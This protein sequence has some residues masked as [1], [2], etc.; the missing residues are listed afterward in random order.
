MTTPA[1]GIAVN[2]F[3][4]KGSAAEVGEMLRLGPAVEAAGF[5]SLWVGDHLLWHTP[6]MDALTLLGGYAATTEHVTL[7]T[8]IYLLG[9]RQPMHAA[10]AI[11]ALNLMSDG[12]LVLG[13][14]VGGE[15]PAEFEASGVSHAERGRLLDRALEV[16]IDQWDP[17]PSGLKVAPLGD[18]V[19]LFVGGRSD[20]A[21]R[22][23]ARFRAGWL[24]AFVTPERIH[25]ESERLTAEREEPVPVAANI[26][27]RVGDDPH[28]AA[29]Q[30]AA[31]LGEIYAM[32]GAPFMRYAVTG[33]PESCVE[34]LAAYAA[35]GVGH[36][37]LR[38]AAWEQTEQIEEWAATLLPL[39]DQSRLRAA[40][41]RL[42]SASGSPLSP[43]TS[44]GGQ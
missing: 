22:R 19:P 28:A 34:Q 25:N 1:W 21:R 5:D 24:A 3:C 39:L 7:G 15:N 4:R 13:V 20:A 29:R 26:Y 18:P 33:P 27:L 32:D 9:L 38:A 40:P 8:G 31:F 16:L 30:A 17:D 2:T 44:A 42:R 10:K 41:Q 37:I 14:G 43:L 12:R 35:A 11:T 23:I 6:I 36:F